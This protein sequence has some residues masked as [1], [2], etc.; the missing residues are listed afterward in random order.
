M[1]LTIAIPVYNGEKTISRCLQSAINQDTKEEYQI[2]VVN[3]ASTDNTLNLINGYKEKVENLTVVANPKTVTMCENHN[4]CINHS[5]TEFILFLHADD[6]LLPT[7]VESICTKIRS[8]NYPENYILWGR[9]LYNDYST[10]YGYDNIFVSNSE[11]LDCF[12]QGGL[13]P[14]GTTYSKKLLDSFGGFPELKHRAPAFDWALLLLSVF[15]ANIFY[16]Q[17][18]TFFFIRTYSSIGGKNTRLDDY[19]CHKEALDYCIERLSQQERI[20]L[21][22]CIY[23]K[24]SLLSDYISSI[25]PSIKSDHRKK[26][27]LKK[28]IKYILPFGLVRF[29]QMYKSR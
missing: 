28:I 12:I 29:I 5:K 13:T 8:R 24:N 26:I 10:R 14:S 22:R 20:V 11:V 23:E 27:S 3:N 15:S 16:E 2:L 25:F 17:A 4:I 21:V 6:Y 18:N 7:A 9:S 1:L 19:E